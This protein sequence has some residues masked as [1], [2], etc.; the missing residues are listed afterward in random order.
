MKLKPNE[1]QCVTVNDYPIT[2]LYNYLEEK[3]YGHIFYGIIEI[4]IMRV[5]IRGS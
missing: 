2:Y 4:D 5:F 1:K 3:C